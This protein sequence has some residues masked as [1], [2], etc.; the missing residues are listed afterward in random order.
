MR[1]V[2]CNECACD[3][4]KTPDQPGCPAAQSRFQGYLFRS[5]ERTRILDENFYQG[6][7]QIVNATASMPTTRT[8]LFI[9]YGFNRFPGRGLCS[10]LSGFAPQDHRFGSNPR[11]TNDRLQNILKIAVNKDIR[12]YTTDS[13]GLYT[14]AALGGSTFDASTGSGAFI[15]QT[16]YL[17]RMTIAR[18]NTDALSELAR[19]T[20]GL[21]FENN[22]DL[23]K[24]ARVCGRA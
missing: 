24:G 1:D 8:I 12:F 10:V 20:G 19:E 17:N 5:S 22:N 2:Y 16:V 9:S 14:G 13:R 6:L 15:P 3:A 23:L 11:D 4:F 21:F 18:E 7:K